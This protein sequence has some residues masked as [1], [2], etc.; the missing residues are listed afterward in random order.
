MMLWK[1]GDASIVIEVTRQYQTIE[2]L[3][4]DMWHAHPAEGRSI[5]IRYK[6]E[7]SYIPLDCTIIRHE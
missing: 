6:N 7:F 3:V 5:F 4:M 1:N 2:L